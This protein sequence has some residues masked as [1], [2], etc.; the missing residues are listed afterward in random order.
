MNAVQD[1]PTHAELAAFGL[2]KLDE[3]AAEPI[4]SHLAV[5]D[6]CLAT[7]AGLE[8]DTFI[9]LIERADKV[10]VPT[11]QGECLVTRDA[12][13]D[14]NLIPPELA[15]HPR[16]LTFEL[17][18]CGDMGDVYRAKHRLMNRDVALKVINRR[19]VANEAAVERFRR[20]VQTAALL[21]HPNIVASHDAEQIGDLHFL[22][23]EYVIGTDLAKI[24]Q[25]RGPQP[26]EIA[27]DWI[28]QVAR[29][30]Q[31]A[32]DC[33]MVHRDI[34][35]HN[36]MV[37][38]G[39]V[40]KIL[41][42][43]LAT[44]ASVAE[45]M[46]SGEIESAGVVDETSA[47]R[48]TRTGTMMGT[49]DFVSPEQ[50]VTPQSADAR[51]DIYSLGCTLYYLLTGAAPFSEETLVDKLEAHQKREPESANSVRADIPE[52]LSAIISRMM[53]KKPAARFQ[54]AEDVVEALAPWCRHPQPPRARQFS[55]RIQAVA[56]TGGM[57]LLLFAPLLKLP[58]GDDPRT[59]QRSQ[60]SGEKSSSE[61]PSDKDSKRSSA[62]PPT[63]DVNES[64]AFK[65]AE[66]RTLQ[67][68][69]PARS[70]ERP[71]GP[72]LNSSGQIY[73]QDGDTIRIHSSSLGE[74][75]A[76]H[77]LAYNLFRIFP[78]EMTGEASIWTR[79]IPGDFVVRKAATKEQIVSDLSR[80]LQ[81]E[82]KVDASLGWIDEETKVWLVDG[83]FLPAP[84][85]QPWRRPDEKSYVLY[86][87]SKTGRLFT[88]DAGSFNELL[89]EFGSRTGR[90]VVSKLDLSPSGFFGWQTFY[91][92]RERIN[93][94]EFPRHYARNIDLVAD[95]LSKQTG[96]KFTEVRQ[97]VRLLKA[98]PK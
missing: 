51:S 47:L 16:Y 4:S 61:K 13:R 62:G 9:D 98:S 32:H 48:L 90:P 45:V 71:Y 89:K 52:T 63:F 86:G 79:K 92:D 28:S 36:L 74:P 94:S 43:G 83:E 39:G 29:G 68:I 87:A 91:D 81:D 97:T 30:L 18:G 64:S 17:V 44:I 80:I 78:C 49:P 88:S 5:C 73:E 85:G 31:H 77:R 3:S 75:Q 70:I 20:E 10:V 33:G 55:K 95:N 46:S 76:L 22:V 7:L 38:P 26:V 37:T 34:K 21:S 35:P 53:A 60:T 24:V 82:I 8:S 6:P 69:P 1:H 93:W 42:F 14:P 15:E 58:S 96:L 12:D 19:L 27:C 84:I 2:G 25:L 23:M 65:V 54:S 41:D 59:T 72:H 56:L 50:V 67:W 66:G 11:Q 57:V 40:V